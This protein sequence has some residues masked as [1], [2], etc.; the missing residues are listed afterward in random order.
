M[1]P[2]NKADVDNSYV[3][4]TGLCYVETFGYGGTRK[5]KK[6]AGWIPTHSIIRYAGNASR[7]TSHSKSD[8]ITPAPAM[9]DGKLGILSASLLD[10]P[11]HLFWVPRKTAQTVQEISRF[12]R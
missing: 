10:I 8:G 12:L 2:F 9:A 3:R 6:K 11:K 1:I 4:I 5:T 7:K